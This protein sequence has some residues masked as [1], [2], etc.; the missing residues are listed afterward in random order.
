MKVLMPGSG[1]ALRARKGGDAP[2]N[3]ALGGLQGR[4]CQALIHRLLPA[5]EGSLRSLSSASEPS[6]PGAER[7]E[8]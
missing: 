1:A 8:G 6:V 7:F 2:I 5:G 4:I 3:N